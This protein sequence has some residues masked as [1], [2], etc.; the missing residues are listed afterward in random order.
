MPDK[1][2][3]YVHQHPPRCISGLNAKPTRHHKP[4]IRL[5][6]HLTIY[7]GQYGEGDIPGVDTASF[8]IG[9]P[10]GCPAVYL[11][12]YYVTS[13]G[14]R[15]DTIFAGPLSLECPQCGAVSE[16]F[17]TRKHGYD[18]EQ[19]LN[20]SILGKGKPDRFA[21]PR[22]GERPVIVCPNFSYQGIEEFLGEMRERRE[23][24]FNSLD[25]VVQCTK[26]NSL[27]EATS[28]ECD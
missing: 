1:F 18:G 9:C 16:F 27:V 10:C 24:F 25:I 17:D 3:Q 6:G 4:T 11:L 20:T 5:P 28:F 21:C 23:D 13:E 8:A 14:C 26:C 2:V 15:N 22:C 7:H 19:G 12:G